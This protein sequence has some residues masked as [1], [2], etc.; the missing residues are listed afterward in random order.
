GDG[1]NDLATAN[2]LSD[3]VSILL[4]LTNNPAPKYLAVTPDTLFFTAV[5]G[6][7][8]PARQ[9][10]TVSET[11]GGSIAFTASE[12]SDWFNLNPYS[13]TTPK[14]VRVFVYISGLGI[15]TYLDSVEISSGEAV[16]SPQYL[17]V[18]LELTPARS[19]LVNDDGTPGVDCDCISIQ[20][21]IDSA[22]AGDTVKVASGTYDEQV[23]MKAGVDLLGGYENTDW[24]RDIEANPTTITGDGQDFVVDLSFNSH[25]HT[26]LD[27]FIVSSSGTL[28]LRKTEENGTISNIM[29]SNNEFVGGSNAAVYF[30]VTS[31][32]IT[33]K[34]NVIHDAGA[35]IMMRQPRK[36]HIEGNVIYN[37][38][39]YGFWAFHCLDRAVLLNNTIVDCNRGISV[40]NIYAGMELPHEFRRNIVVGGSNV[41]VV[42]SNQ[43]ILSCNDIYDNSPD[44]YS[45]IVPAEDDISYDPLFC[46]TANGEFSIDA[47]S[48]CAPNHPLNPC[49]ELIG[50]LEPGCENCCFLRGDIDHSEV[51]PIDI[52]DLVYLVD[53][54]FNEG[55]APV[56]WGEGDVDG[57]GVEPIDIA[58]LVYLVDYMFNSGPEPPPCP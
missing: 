6:G 49:G 42:C 23:F 13:G 11:G 30:F 12:S 21:C 53:Y 15:N 58:D 46:D 3:N 48:P 1:D 10:F 34:G 8:D 25:I 38:S 52:A 51:L 9:E 41:G 31:D 4:N 33:V 50:A 26:V 2:A 45:T 36:M 19:W 57:S 40:G 7:T 32:S 37:C 29:V 14:S 16:N 24:T 27:G 44:Y 18:W 56:C 35:G 28:G 54:M 20:A 5:A 22:G 17:Y 47:L 55:P 43:P 39:S